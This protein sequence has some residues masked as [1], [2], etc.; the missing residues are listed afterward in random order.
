M[1]A[2]FKGL[3]SVLLKGGHD[4]TRAGVCVDNLYI[5]VGESDVVSSHPIPAPYLERAAGVAVTFSRV[6]SED[7]TAH[8]LKIAYSHARIVA[9]NDHGTG[10]SLASATAASLAKLLHTHEQ[11]S[12][13]TDVAYLLRLLPLAVL[14]GVVFVT[15]SIRAASVYRVGAGH[16]PLF[17]HKGNVVL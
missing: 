1:L 14:N 2:S 13:D 10:C 16:G 9:Q 3:R 11:T 12:T 6:S 5:L 15:S 7:G 8:A 17:H 4:T